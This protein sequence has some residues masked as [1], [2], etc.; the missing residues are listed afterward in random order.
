MLVRLVGIAALAAA[1]L[2]IA[3]D[4]GNG[5]SYSDGPMPSVREALACDGH[6]YATRQTAP[7][8]QTTWE[9][10]PE[11][12]LQSGL[13]QSEQ[14]WL[15]SDVVRVSART[16]GRVLFVLRR[17]LAA[18]ASP[19]RSSAAV[20]RTPTSGDCRPGRCATHQSSSGRTPAASGTACGWTPRASRRRPAT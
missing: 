4:M 8:E 6:V 12:A 7:G 13:L 20:A 1:G 5:P 11:T 18:P 9:P 15:E 2:V 3:Y 14:W 19:P 16:D 10:T 17:Q